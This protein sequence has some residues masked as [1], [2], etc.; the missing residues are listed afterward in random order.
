ME[1]KPHVKSVNALLY[2]PVVVQ[3]DIE[4]LS[5]LYVCNLLLFY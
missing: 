1:D 3:W 5:L 4:L 2:L